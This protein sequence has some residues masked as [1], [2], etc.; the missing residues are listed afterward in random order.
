MLRI[1]KEPRLREIPCWQPHPPLLTS[2]GKK[3]KRWGGGYPFDV[4]IHMDPSSAQMRA[5][6]PYS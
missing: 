2:V 1:R 4:K 3:G 5:I 6:S